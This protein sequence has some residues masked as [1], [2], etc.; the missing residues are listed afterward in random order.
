MKKTMI[1]M[2]LLLSGATI[3]FGQLFKPR[4]LDIGDPTFKNRFVLVIKD[5]PE[6]GKPERV[7][8]KDFS[9]S[10]KAFDPEKLNI[11]PTWKFINYKVYNQDHSTTRYLQLRNFETGKYLHYKSGKLS[12]KDE[13]EYLETFEK[14]CYFSE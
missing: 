12:L 10:E 4:V 11:Y 2:V 9:P 13:K 1:I 14:A 3:S 6:S 8:E 7:V 5:N